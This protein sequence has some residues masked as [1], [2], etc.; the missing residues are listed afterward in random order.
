MKALFC[1][2]RQVS[3]RDIEKPLR[4]KGEVLIRVHCAGI[5]STDLEILKGYVPGFNGVPG[6][7]FFGFIEE[8]DNGALPGK[9]AT[10]AGICQGAG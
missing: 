4:N 8:A 1:E 3:L 10:A 5:C 7:E 6:H 9:R 2:N